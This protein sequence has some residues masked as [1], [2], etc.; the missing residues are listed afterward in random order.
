MR[1]LIG[2]PIPM[3]F[4]MDARV[5]GMVESYTKYNG[6]K[7]YYPA[8]RSACEGQDN[9]VK[10]ALSMEPKPTHI[11]ICDYDVLLRPHTV[12][13]LASLD[14]DV[15]SAVYPNSID[16][17]IG[18]CISKD[19]TRESGKYKMMPINELPD[20]PFQ[21]NVLSNGAMLVKMEVFEK[22][23]W[24]YWKDE[25]TEKG[26]LGHDLYFFDK[27]KKA[28]IELWVDPT[29]KCNHFKTVDLLG[30]AKNYIKE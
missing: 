12:G 18:W 5:I 20:E 11:M 16:G 3:D 19:W 28:G 9:I 14:K 4:K 2:V 24:P 22:L 23:D 10:M 25:K 27:C 30:I 8:T 26:F 29:L 1:V 21:A 6:V 13:K 17:E 7:T 15:V